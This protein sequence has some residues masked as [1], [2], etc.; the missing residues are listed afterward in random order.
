MHGERG[1]FYAPYMP[2]TY[3]NELFS[4]GR[5]FSTL[6]GRSTDI[7]DDGDLNNSNYELSSMYFL[8]SSILSLHSVTKVQY[9]QSQN[10]ERVSMYLREKLIE[11]GT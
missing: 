8:N 10:P 3:A 1:R 9:L 4:W 5:S 2:H 11:R 6:V 7:Q